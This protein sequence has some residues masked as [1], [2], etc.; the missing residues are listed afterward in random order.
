[1]TARCL[2]VLLMAAISVFGWGQSQTQ[3]RFAL[4]AGQVARALSEKGMPT[5]DGQVS[6]LTRVVA[7]ESSPALDVLSV[8][9]LSQTVRGRALQSPLASQA[10]LSS[11][12]Q[13]STLLCHRDLVTN[14][15]P[16]LPSRPL[17]YRPGSTI[18]CQTENM[19]ITMR[20][21]THATL[22]MDDQPVPYP[23]RCHQ[24]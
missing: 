13:M 24:P 2:S 14:L 23:G 18:R 20:A 21:G 17:T 3:N 16:G 9:M 8:E 1:M 12:G 6:L 19:D 10:G 22:V 5:S 7:T 4:T 11:T 15:R